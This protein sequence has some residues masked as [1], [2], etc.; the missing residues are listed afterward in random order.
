MWE[1]HTVQVY[2]QDGGYSPFV[3]TQEPPPHLGHISKIQQCS[4][5][6]KNEKKLKIKTQKLIKKLLGIKFSKIWLFLDK[7]QTFKL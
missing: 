1:S 3:Y 2:V 7:H 6:Q 5:V 4:T